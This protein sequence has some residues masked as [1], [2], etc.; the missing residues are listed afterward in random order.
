MKGLWEASVGE[1]A[2]PGIESARGSTGVTFG[3]PS[4]E[5]GRLGLIDQ[6]RDSTTPITYRVYIL[7]RSS[8]SILTYQN[9]RFLNVDIGVVRAV[10]STCERYS[11]NMHRLDVERAYTC[12]T[13]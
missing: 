2:G 11:K 5:W 10:S 8:T 7:I 9:N 1:G 12:G 4:T 3:G 13:R 6:V